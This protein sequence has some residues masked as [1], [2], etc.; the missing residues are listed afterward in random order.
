MDEP[1]RPLGPD[2]R[3][4][5]PEAAFALPGNGTWGDSLRALRAAFE[6]GADGT[7]VAGSELV[8]RVD[9]VDA[10]HASQHPGKPTGPD[11]GEHADGYGLEHA[12]IDVVRAVVAGAVT[13][14]PRRRSDGTGT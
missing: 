11:V 4:L 9:V 12:G 13:A 6:S 8:E 1:D 3:R 14:S 5:P 10:G 2:D 7:A